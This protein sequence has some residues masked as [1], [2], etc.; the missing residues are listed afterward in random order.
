[1]VELDGGPSP[2]RTVKS[3]VIGLVGTAPDAD[4]TLFP[5]KSPQTA[6]KTITKGQQPLPSIKIK[7]M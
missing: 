3:S 6:T 7:T 4:A 1:M 2:I 5:L